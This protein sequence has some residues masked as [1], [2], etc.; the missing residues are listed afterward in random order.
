MASDTACNL[1]L[2]LVAENENA[3]LALSSAGYTAHYEARGLQHRV[4]NLFEKGASEEL[5]ALLKSG[6]VS[7]VYAMAGVGG[8]LQLN[9]GTNLWTAAGLPFLALWYDHP[10]YHY[11]QHIVDSPNIVHV[12]HAQDHLDARLKHLPATRSRSLLTP[13][14]CE[15]D[16]RSRS[17][18]FAARKNR[19]MFAKT[20]YDPTSWAKDWQ[21][22]PPQLRG[23]LFDLA[24]EAEKDRNLDLSDAAKRLFLAQKLDVQNL[25]AFMGVI[26][27]VDAYIRAWRSDKFAHALLQHDADII[28]RGWDYLQDA[29]R[30]ATISPAIPAAQYW[31]QVRHYKIVANT[32]PLWRDGIHE[33]AVAAC[34]M[35]AV[36]LTDRTD[37][38]DFAFADLPNYV[39]FDWHDDLGDVIQTAFKR[40]E[41]DGDAWHEAIDRALVEKLHAGS[42]DY[43]DRILHIVQ[44]LKGGR[45]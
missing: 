18:P 12:Y 13:P 31:E 21:R 16:T 38:S 45:A 24:A 37:K 36:V 2:A 15:I 11:S 40:A 26:Q 3:T 33:R 30:R 4:L 42:N 20:A 41:Q 10:A 43:V 34:N 8:G 25:D 32:S 5:I 22:H 29:P 6:T 17:V 44:T 14:P 1:V 7:F 35:G 9:D 27:E 39:G 23:V 28:G 19:I